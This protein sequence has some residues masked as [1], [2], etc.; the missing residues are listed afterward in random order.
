MAVYLIMG[1]IVG[2]YFGTQM[3]TRIPADK[4]KV[5]LDVGI[6][7]LGLFTLGMAFYRM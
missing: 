3:V 1:S 5:I 6:L 7:F 2:I 4:F